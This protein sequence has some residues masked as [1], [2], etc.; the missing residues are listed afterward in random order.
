[1]DEL[2]LT[3][4]PVEP[5]LPQLLDKLRIKPGSSYVDELNALVDQARHIARPKGLYQVVPIDHKGDDTVT[6]NGITLNSRILR[7]NLEQANRVFPFV[8][9]GGTELEQ[10]VQSI[11][12]MLYNFCAD[13]IADQA[14]RSAIA[15]L[16]AQ[17][18]NRYRPVHLAVMHPGS[19]ADVPIREQKALFDLLGDTKAAIGVELLDSLLMS[20][21]KSVSGIY[22]P[23]EDSFESCQLCPVENCPNRRAPYDESL[24][25]RKYC[26]AVN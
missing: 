7:V 17:I 5:D 18:N 1:M 12:D 20:P 15:A 26:P 4:I 8:A 6:I 9:T 13:A 14:L 10:W 21:T 3:N 23:T 11:K 24:Y 25:E 22:F 16:L 19:L 2:I